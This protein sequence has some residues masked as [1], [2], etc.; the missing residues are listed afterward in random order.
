M[1]DRVLILVPASCFP[2]T[3]FPGKPLASIAGKS[4]IQRVCENPNELKGNIE[5]SWAVVT[6]DDKIENHLKDF[7]F[8]CVR[9]DDD[10][11]S[12]TERIDLALERHFFRLKW[13]SRYKCSR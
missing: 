2:S 12:G 10:V 7:N 5:W 6:D 8:N 4:L 9:I 1:T 13:G 3:R 11:P